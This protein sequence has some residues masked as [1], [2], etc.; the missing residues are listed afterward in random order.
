MLKEIE[1]NFKYILILPDQFPYSDSFSGS[2]RTNY[3]DVIY[4][5]INSLGIIYLCN[6]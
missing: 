1:L 2:G 5:L 3:Y 4:S 6:L